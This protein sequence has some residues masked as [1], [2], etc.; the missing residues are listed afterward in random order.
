MDASK[1]YKKKGSTPLFSLCFGLISYWS[2]LV[3]QG[4]CWVLA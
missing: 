2:A 4:F 1:S 3:S